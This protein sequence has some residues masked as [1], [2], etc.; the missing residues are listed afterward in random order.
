MEYLAKAQAKVLGPRL[1]AMNDRLTA[2]EAQA[3]IG[4]E[5]KTLADNYH[6]VWRDGQQHE[7]GTLV[8]HRSSLWLCT[9]GTTGKPG[10]SQSW[11]LVSKNGQAPRDTK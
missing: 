9:K 10:N 2:L 1:K 5:S 4:P 6:G 3:G 7:R 11:R 8:T